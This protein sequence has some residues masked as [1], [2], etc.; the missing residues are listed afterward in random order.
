MWFLF[1]I[2]GLGVW[3]AAS[4]LWGAE[5]VEPVVVTASKLP[6]TA[7]N[8]TQKVDV[9]ESQNLSVIVTGHRNI[10]DYLIYQPG[11]FSNV[12]S[13]NDANWGSVGGLSQK[14]NT[15][16]LEGLPIDVFV[17]P[18]A[19]E[20]LVVDR[21]EVQ[22]GPAAVLYPNYLGMD[23]AGNQSPLT[24]TTNI[25][26]KERFPKPQTIFDAYYGSYATFGG[27]VLHQQPIGDVHFFLGASVEDS[28]YTN[29][30][31]KDSWLNMI[32]DPEYRKTKFYGGTTWF[33]DGND[34]HKVSFFVNRTNHQGD[35]GRPNRGF[36]HDYWTIH[37]AYQLPLSE[38]LTAAAK[39]GYRNY[40]RSWQEDNYPADLTLREKGGV[41]QEI[42]PAD[43]SVAYEHWGGS[44]L[45]VGADFQSASYK[46]Y[47]N[48]GVR[49]VTNDADAVQYGLYAQEELVW[50]R[51]VFRLGGRYAYTKH[52]VDL[53]GGSTPEDDSISWDKWLWSAGVR[54]HFLDNLAAYA[55]VGSSF[56]APSI[57]SVG[58]T[59]RAS[60]RGV[61]GKDG[62]LPN[63]DLDPESGIG[64][65]LGVDWKPLQNVTFGVRGFY[66]KVN[67]Q[68]V[69]VVVSQKPSQA[70]DI[71]AGD[72]TS[73][74]FELEAQYRPV[75]WMRCF[76]NY[77]YTDTEIDNDKDPDMDGAEVPFVPR[78]MGNIGVDMNLPYDFK[79]SVY[80]HLAGKIYDSTSKQ[81]RNRFS[82]YEVLNAYVEKTLLEKDTTNLSFYAQFYNITD[83]QYEMP[84][85]FQDPGFAFTG[86]FKL[87][88]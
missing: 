10:A 70:Q 1:L 28:D 38:T 69:Q 82:G 55:N 83:N 20:M 39:I 81:N 68:I 37:S 19:L 67:D 11:V 24:G 7:G 76:A 17:E 9:L 25:F 60:D 16:M 41:R 87:T 88:F 47:T 86:G 29:Y 85:Q 30:G 71:N 35:A 27:R 58:G 72:T 79:V 45:T 12:L 33:I 49:S 23:F 22:R 46:T 43:L 63:P 3:P 62:R 51:T 42:V 75:P 13:R 14:Y 66:N 31:T 5:M 50:G 40:D 18:Q 44:L 36:D 32:D 4:R 73:M 57:H 54:H 26:L 84:W 80:L 34:R 53:L 52:D 56:V 48:P 21:I 74:G 2:L 64:A 78:N 59:L 77:T 65:D 61:P 15:Y 8:V 6:R